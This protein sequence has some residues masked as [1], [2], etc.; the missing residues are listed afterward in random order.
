MRLVGNICPRQW[1]SK[2]PQLLASVLTALPSTEM[3]HAQGIA[4]IEMS[5]IRGRIDADSI[6]SADSV[7]SRGGAV[8]DYGCFFSVQPYQFNPVSESTPRTSHLLSYLLSNVQ[9]L[10]ISLDDTGLGNK[11]EISALGGNDTAAKQLL[12]VEDSEAALLHQVLRG[13]EIAFAPFDRV[14]LDIAPLVR[15]LPQIPDSGRICSWDLGIVSLQ[16]LF[17][18]LKQLLPQRFWVKRRHRGY[19]GTGSVSYAHR[20]VSSDK[21]CCLDACQLHHLAFLNPPAKS[22]ILKLNPLPGAGFRTYTLSGWNELLNGETF[23]R[24]V[25]KW[26]G[27]ISEFEFGWTACSA[28]WHWKGIRTDRAGYRRRSWA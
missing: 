17:C 22:G 12:M 7:P 27:P 26:I 8:S 3:C 6:R 24:G 15:G 18:S 1:G 16:Q 14:G 19:P 13:L 11:G 25:P 10:H 23:P 5:A 2:T 4:K 9:R 21:E 28:P 20:F